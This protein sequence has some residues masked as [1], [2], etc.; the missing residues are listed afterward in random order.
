MHFACTITLHDNKERPHQA[1]RQRTPASLW[2]PPLRQL[3]KVIEPPWY[4][5][6]HQV[7]KVSLTGEIKWCGGLVFIGEALAREPVGIIEIDDGIHPVGVCNR[8]LGTISCDGRFHRFALP[9]ARLRYTLV[10]TGTS[11]E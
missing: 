1:L 3:P 4:D 7:R 10:S 6:D 9:R 2:Q 5:A 11:N 8:D